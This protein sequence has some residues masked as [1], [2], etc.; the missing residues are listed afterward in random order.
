MA[1]VGG[2]VAGLLGLVGGFLEV[3]LELLLDLEE[4]GLLLDEVLEESGMG[5]TV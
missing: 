5:S 4:G 2:V 3:V 1:V